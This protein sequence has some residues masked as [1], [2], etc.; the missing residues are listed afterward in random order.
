MGVGVGGVGVNILECT[1]QELLTSPSSSHL[2]GRG[3][4]SSPQMYIVTP[5]GGNW[6]RRRG[7]LEATDPP[8]TTQSG[9]EFQTVQAHSQSVHLLY[10]GHHP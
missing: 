1:N 6:Y 7:T 2:Q 5:S 10:E 9:G 3:S 8:K 4:A